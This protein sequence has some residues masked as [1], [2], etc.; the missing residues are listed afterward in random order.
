MAKDKKPLALI[1]NLALSLRQEFRWLHQGLVSRLENRESRV[2]QFAASQFD[3]GVT[4]VTLAFGCYLATIVG[5]SKVAV[6]EANIRKPCFRELLG[7]QTDSGLQAV[8]DEKAD[9]DD[10]CVRVNGLGICAIPADRAPDQTV[11]LPVDSGL[12]TAQRGIADV[13]LKLRDRFRFVLLDSPPI[14]P[15]MDG[16]VL[17]AAVDGVVFVIESNRTRAEVVENALGKLKSSGGNILGTVLNKRV[18]HIP[19]FLYRLL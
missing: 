11:L 16:C 18:F 14:I 5:D 8:V 17:A 2:V 7:I 1:D 12:Y 3:E 13:I 15:F 9:L 10:V 4:T 19:Q 6:V